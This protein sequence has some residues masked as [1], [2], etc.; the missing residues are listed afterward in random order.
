M[1]S[2]RKPHDGTR[3][4]RSYCIQHRTGD[5][6]VCEKMHRPASDASR[7]MSQL[8]QKAKFHGEQRTSALAQKADTPSLTARTKSR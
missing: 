8:G 3:Q 6:S 2:G 1:P 7:P 5:P 4:R